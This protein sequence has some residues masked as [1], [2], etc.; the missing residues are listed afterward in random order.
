[1]LLHQEKSVFL[2][3]LKYTKIRS[4][5]VYL[6]L[7]TFEPWTGTDLRRSRLVV[8]FIWA[9]MLQNLAIHVCRRC[10]EWNATILVTFFQST[11]T[12]QNS[13]T[14]FYEILWCQIGPFGLRNW[15]V[16]VALF[17]QNIHY[18]AR[19][20]GP[21]F[22]FLRHCETFFQT[23]FSR[24]LFF[25]SFATKWMLKNPQSVPLLQLLA[26]WDCSKRD[27]LFFKSAAIN[28]M[29]FGNLFKKYLVN[30]AAK[31]RF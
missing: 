12:D 6:R 11:R 2:D 21:S 28:S 31:K 16:K 25:R 17:Q 9:E 8:M 4:K 13:S 26:L 1:M 14:K 18:R 15:T 27:L 22:Q 24:S 3:F 30:R 20:K 19:L 7:C 10:M 23:V 5:R 29:F